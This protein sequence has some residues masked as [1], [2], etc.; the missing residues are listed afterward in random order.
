MNNKVLI[1]GGA[2]YIGSHASVTLLESNYD[3]IILDNFCNSSIDGARRV[4]E[5]SNKSVQLID[6]DIRDKQ[7]LRKIFEQNN[8]YAVL[9]FAG[10]KAVAESVEGPLEYYENN[11]AGTISLCQVMEEASVR[12]L[13]FSSSATVYGEPADNPVN[14]RCQ[15]GKLN[16]PYGRSKLMVEEILRDIAVS[17]SAWNIAILRYFNPAGAHP[18]GLI[19]ENPKGIPNNLVPYIGQVAAGWR[20]VLHIFGDDYSTLDGTGVRDYIHVQDLAEGHLSALHAI[21]ERS[22]L[23]IWNLGTGRGYSVL[24][25]IR[26]F[27]EASGTSINFKVVERRPGDVAE[28]WADPTKAQVDLNWKAKRSLIEMM[29]DAWRWQRNCTISG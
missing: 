5:I 16:S 10:L 23:N 1:T 17:N 29:V 14:E 12:R 7:C 9:H 2:G 3:V 13:V 11:V 24:E 27:E 28:C 20:D 6:G 25:V 8:V 22:G 21:G 26:A 19:G 4:E 18:S 15:V